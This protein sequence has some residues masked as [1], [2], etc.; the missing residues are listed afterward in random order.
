M[1]APLTPEVFELAGSPPSDGKTA[2][3]AVL[4]GP[5]G[6]VLS[7]QS[8]AAWWG[9]PGFYLHRDTAITVP[10]QGTP[11]RGR[12]STIHYHQDLPQ[13]QLVVLRGIWITSP[14]L[15][16]FHLAAVVSPHRTARACDNAWSMRLV[17]G[18]ELDQLFKVLAASGR[19]GIGPMREILKARPVEYIPPQSGL[20]A[21]YCQLVVQD[22][23]PEPDRQVNI[24]SP[25]WIGRV[26][27]RFADVCLI[28]ELLSLRY[29]GSHSDGLADKQRFAELRNSGHS[30]LAFWDFEVWNNPGFVVQR[31]RWAR[32]TLK[33]GG[34]LPIDDPFSRINRNP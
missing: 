8:A 2:M 9:L 33:A 34:V 31:T 26:D 15:T 6:A 3:A 12:L 30:V 11:R 18:F 25:M 13:D 22:G 20:E 14:A 16:I 32:E 19:N 24:F 23:M 29:H 27:V 10:R 1:L 4:D 28:V 21:R 7:H 17:D 5:P